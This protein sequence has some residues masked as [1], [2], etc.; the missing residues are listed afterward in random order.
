MQ[1]VIKKVS[2]L[3]RIGMTANNNNNTI[4]LQFQSHNNLGSW[5]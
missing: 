2:F 1:Q 3:G 4:R 5:Y